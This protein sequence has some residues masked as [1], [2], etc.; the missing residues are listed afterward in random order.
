MIDFMYENNVL[1]EAQFGFCKNK[2]TESAL[3]EFTDF[4][5]T[6]LTKKSNVGTVFMDLSKAFDVMSHS[7][8]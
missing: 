5:Y 2:N 7:V 4:V 1:T 8:L 3:I 6:A